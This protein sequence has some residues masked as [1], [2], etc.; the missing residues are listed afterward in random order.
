MLAMN[1]L[2]QIQTRFQGVRQKLKSNTPWL[3]GL[4]LSAFVAI[5]LQ[6]TDAQAFF[7]II[8]TKLTKVITDVIKTGGIMIFLW[9]IGEIIAMA[10]KRG[11][12]TRMAI[13]I[14][15]GVLLTIASQIKSY[16][17]F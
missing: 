2:S 3:K 12:P 16:F 11:N 13:T 7:N 8:N 1:K 6:P 15:C 9:F 10:M 14:G 17:G 4:P 5:S